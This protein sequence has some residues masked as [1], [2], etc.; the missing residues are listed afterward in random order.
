M[1]KNNPQLTTSEAVDLKENPQLA[2]N[3][4]VE[5]KRSD[6]Y[7]H[8]N[9]LSWANC[10]LAIKNYQKST[11]HFRGVNEKWRLSIGN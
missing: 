10:Q 7:L 1:T 6:N 4:L 2:T 5:L 3:E 8:M 9:Q 11:N